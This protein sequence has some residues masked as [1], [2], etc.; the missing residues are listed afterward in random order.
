MEYEVIPIF[1]SP[2]YISKNDYTLD[3]KEINFIK[4][5]D[6]T[7]YNINKQ[8]KNQFILNEVKLTGLKNFI[9]LHLENYK[10]EILKPVNNFDISIT[11]SWI[12]FYDENNY[13]HTHDHPNSFLSGIFYI[14]SNNCPTEFDIKNR[15][16]NLDI[17]P[18]KEYNIF[19]CNSWQI[20]PENFKLVLFPS[21]VLHK[22]KINSKNKQRI[23][24]SFNTYLKG[25]IGDNLYKLNV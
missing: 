7:D 2:I 25:E 20:C 15:I 9:T 23:T 10:Q 3:N 12:N 4:Q 14:E 16:F 21:T 17:G 18:V 5:L 11:Q 6:Y 8:T 22:T 19:N 24:L 13:I 1:S